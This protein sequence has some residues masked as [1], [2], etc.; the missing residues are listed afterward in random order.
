MRNHPHPK[1][2]ETALRAL[3]ALGGSCSCT[4]AGNGFACIARLLNRPDCTQLSLFLIDVHFGYL[5]TAAVPGAVGGGG[6]GG[7]EENEEL[8]KDDHTAEGVVVLTW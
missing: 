3:I 2:G 5:Q 1:A 7:G 4:A 8:E 6:G